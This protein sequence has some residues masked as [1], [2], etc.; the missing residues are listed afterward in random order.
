[1][2]RPPGSG[3]KKDREGWRETERDGEGERGE[4][5][6]EN[7]AESLTLEARQ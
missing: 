2:W 5:E 1:M 7:K 6:R 4:G 3:D